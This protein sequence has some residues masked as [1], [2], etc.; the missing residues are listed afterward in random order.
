VRTIRSSLALAAV[1]LLV[2]CSGAPP[3]TRSGPPVWVW[4]AEPTAHTVTV[5]IDT[6]PARTAVEYLAAATDDEALLAAAVDSARTSG[7]LRSFETDPEVFREALRGARSKDGSSPLS[8]VAARANQLRAAIT[9][10][11]EAR[12][13]I[14]RDTSSRVV[15]LLPRS[16]SVELP[17][18][19][20]LSLGIGRTASLVP[21]PAERGEGMAL[22]PA[23]VVTEREGT[24]K[25]AVL[26]LV[27]S[28]IAPALWDRARDRSRALRP[29]TPAEPTHRQRLALE[30]FEVGPRRYLE[31]SNAFLPLNRW[32]A[33]P[34]RNAFR[35]LAIEARRNPDRTD[36]A[37]SERISGEDV[38]MA[39]AALVDG[40]AV[41]LGADRLREA[42]S[43]GP[44]GLFAAW[45]EA[46]ARNS[47]LLPLPE[48][49]VRAASSLPAPAAP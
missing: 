3:P 36:A 30:L 21:L 9:A 5:T 39:G 27:A 19:V 42:L 35:E 17:F 22:D 20:V 23:R 25:D 29:A 18:R 13:E 40:V 2:S 33:Q 34:I 44:A 37:P 8:G 43:R 12:E 11:E 28:R 4:P 47:D 31:L 7:A 49:I 38:A 32:L 6:L 15:H 24:S 14:A 16:P 45:D 10:V 26:D 1:P 46:R 48:E 41:T